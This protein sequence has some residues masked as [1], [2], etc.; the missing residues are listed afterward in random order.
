MYR[1]DFT[2]AEMAKLKVFAA[3]PGY[4]S[5]SKEVPYYRAA[6]LERHL[7]G[8]DELVAELLLGATWQARTP[9]QYTR[10]ATDTLSAYRAVLASAGSDKSERP[11]RELVAGELERRL[12]YFWEAQARFERLLNTKEL[13]QGLRA[14]IVRMQLRLIQ[15][16]DAAPHE[17]PDVPR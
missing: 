15:D 17:A 1:R 6:M 16:R 2:N 8:S 11:D 10:Y 13:K 7:R 5:L 4:A 12:G 9:D 3:S 14:G